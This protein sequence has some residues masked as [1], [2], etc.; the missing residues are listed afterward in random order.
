MAF[1]SR[2]EPAYLSAV[3]LYELK[4]GAELI[5]D[6][7]KKEMLTAWVASIRDT[8][9]AYILPVTVDIAELA[10][11]LQA[12]DHQQGRALHIEDALIAATDIEHNM[13]LVTRNVS[14]FQTTKVDL[15][16]PWNARAN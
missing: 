5:K 4:Y 15:V 12:A 14:D 7:H 3:T 13:V 16:N 6:P 10:A 11:I 9:E 2:G 1:L 8:Y